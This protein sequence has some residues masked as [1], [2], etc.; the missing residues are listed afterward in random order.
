MI[1]RAD[2]VERANAWG[3]AEGVVEKDYVHQLAAV[4]HWL[5][6]RALPVLGVQ[7][8]HVSEEVLLRDVPLLLRTLIS[9]SSRTAPILMISRRSFPKPFV[10]QCRRSWT[11]LGKRSGSTSRA[12][13]ST[14]RKEAKR[15]EPRSARLLQ[16][17]QWIAARREG[18]A[19]HLRDGASSQAHRTDAHS[20]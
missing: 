5:P 12:E 18:E 16:R 2:I 3:L 13:I 8:R 20:A 17:A 10:W 15:E 11:M 1:G 7:G 19:R 6:P 4:G 9:V 14:S